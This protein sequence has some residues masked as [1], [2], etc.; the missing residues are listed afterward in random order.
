MIVS[1]QAIAAKLG[2]AEALLLV[3][4]DKAQQLSL[5]IS[6]DQSQALL[7]ETHNKRAEMEQLKKVLTF[8]SF[9]VWSPLHKSSVPTFF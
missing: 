3:M 7:Q 4:G 5:N 9:L 2:S 6:S 1:L 8:T